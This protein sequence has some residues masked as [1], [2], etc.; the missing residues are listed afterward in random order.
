[1]TKIFDYDY[2][3]AEAFI[4]KNV[5]QPKCNR[6]CKKYLTPLQYTLKVFGLLI[7]HWI[8]FECECS[9]YKPKNIM[10]GK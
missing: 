10:W 3:I 7:F 6:K 1:M 5:L 8:R 9:K 4:N 2:K